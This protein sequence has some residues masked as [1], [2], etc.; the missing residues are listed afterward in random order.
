M[1]LQLGRSKINLALKIGQKQ[2]KFGTKIGSTS[3][4]IDIQIII[5][6][7]G[8]YLKPISRKGASS[9]GSKFSQCDF[10]RSVRLKMPPFLKSFF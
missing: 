7:E 5:L 4:P 10:A 3:Q 9:K 1:A 2:N 8:F 6:K